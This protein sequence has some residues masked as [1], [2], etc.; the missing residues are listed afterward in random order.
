MQLVERYL[1]AIEFWLPRKQSRDIIAEISEDIHSQI[2]EREAQLERSLTESELE[3]LLKQRGRPVLVANRYL[4]QRFLI[5]PML[6][7][8]YAFVLK[9]FGFFYLIPWAVVYMVIHRVQHPDRALGASITA[10]L[11]SVWQ[12]GFIGAAVITV[13]FGI[14]Q[15]CN[16]QASILDCTWSPRKLPR[17]RQPGRISRTDS[18]IELALCLAVLVWWIGHASSPNIL[19]GP[20]VQVSLSPS[21]VVFFWGFLAISVLYATLSSVNLMRPYWTRAR[22]WTRLALDAAGSFL[23]CWLFRADLVESLKIVNVDPARTL[24][25]RDSIQWWM[26]RAF[27]LALI[28]VMIA[29]APDVYR[30]VKV[31]RK[32][33]A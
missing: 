6:F 11:G 28:A 22:A 10:T 8:I 13:V 24:Q 21:W 23:F 19:N 29:L 5:G 7:P 30:I 25:I 3:S 27:P 32:A 15:A 16:V 33:L 12:T 1:H 31:S 14:L 4:P 26:G 20:H 2:E 18:T 17:D 9:M